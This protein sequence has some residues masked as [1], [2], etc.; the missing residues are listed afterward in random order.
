MTIP[1]RSEAHVSGLDHV[2]V[3][4]ADLDR[5]LAFFAGVLGIPVRDRGDLTTDAG[6]AVGHAALR[7]R[8]A[9]L[10]LGEGRTLE[11]LEIHHPPGAPIVND[12]LRPGGTHLALR[13]E[14]I[15][16]LAERA[17]A[18]GYPARTAQPVTLTEPGFW[19]G[20]RILYLDAPGGIT[21]EL[22]ER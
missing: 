6:M 11:L 7:G 18:A 13:V 10:D 15:E 21:V 22:I 1:Q 16:Q 8:F 14:G 4:C 20:A 2:G 5:A 3:A 17:R 9:D 19:H 12:P